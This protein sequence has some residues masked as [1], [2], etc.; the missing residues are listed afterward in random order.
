MISHKHKGNLNIID[1]VFVNIGWLS[2]RMFVYY[3]NDDS[4]RISLKII[5]NRLVKLVN[6]EWL[7]SSGT[8]I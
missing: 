2:S 3:H 7:F 5:I 4:T 6:K 1:N 8:D